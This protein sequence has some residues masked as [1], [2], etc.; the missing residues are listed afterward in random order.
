M[1]LKFKTQ[2]TEGTER[3]GVMLHVMDEI[4]TCGNQRLVL[5][6]PKLALSMPKL[7]F[8]VVSVTK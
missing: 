5:V 1:N 4:N 8:S 7:V 6:S 2:A 3:Q